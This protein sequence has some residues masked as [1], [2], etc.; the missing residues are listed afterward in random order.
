MLLEG[1]AKNEAV[2]FRTGSTCRVGTAG[3][4]GRSSD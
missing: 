1:R 4:I 2:K 3:A